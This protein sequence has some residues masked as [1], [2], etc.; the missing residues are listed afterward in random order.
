LNVVT[1]HARRWLEATTVIV[2]GNGF[3]PHVDQTGATPV[4]DR[5]RSAALLIKR[6]GVLMKIKMLVAGTTLWISS[7]AAAGEL[8]IH[9]IEF[10][11]ALYGEGGAVIT[12]ESASPQ[13]ECVGYKDGVPVGSGSAFTTARIGSVTV[14]L[15]SKP[16]EFTVKCLPAR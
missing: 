8:R 16:E 9:N 12:V 7:T 2:K 10:T 14:L 15:S 4:P 11:S 3:R 5:R 1:D 13:I 6:G